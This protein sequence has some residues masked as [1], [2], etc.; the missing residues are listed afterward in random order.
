MAPVEY[1]KKVLEQI[2]KPTI[3][4]EQSDFKNIQNEINQNK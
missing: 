4:I 1:Y 3:L 2:H